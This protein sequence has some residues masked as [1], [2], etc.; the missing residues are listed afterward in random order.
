MEVYLLS[1]SLTR[2]RAIVPR[3]GAALPLVWELDSSV[4]RHHLPDLPE[5]APE[6]ATPSGSLQR[7]DPR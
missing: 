7:P 6:R 4:P 5:R 3:R 2:H 1:V